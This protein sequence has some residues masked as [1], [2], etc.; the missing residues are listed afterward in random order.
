MILPNYSLHCPFVVDNVHNN[1]RKHWYNS[2][3][4]N[5]FSGTISW[6]ASFGV[7]QL[8][9]QRYS[10]LPTLKQAQSIIYFNI[11]PF[12]ILCTLVSS[13]GLVAL[14]YYYNCSPLE[15]GEIHDTDHIVILFARDHSLDGHLSDAQVTLLNKVLV[16]GIGLV[17]TGLAFAAGPLGGI[18][19]SPYRELFLPTN[20][21]SEGC[22]GLTNNTISLRVAP[23]YDA[24]F[25][26]PEASCLSRISAFSYPGLGFVIMVIIA[27]P[28]TFFEK[29]DE[30][31]R[32]LSEIVDRPERQRVILMNLSESSTSN[33]RE[34]DRITR[35]STKTP[36]TPLID[37]E[38]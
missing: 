13:I 11:I 5:I 31:K 23:H 30:K 17:S 36:L 10:S 16:V 21:T 8:A 2:L 28:L 26:D 7:N 15:T 19:R 29:A 35:V 4:I 33:D 20:T 12:L 27:I 14:A 38:I 6:L 32:Y 25:G 18:I 22:V 9:I 37:K 1:N 24:H 34:M 3:W